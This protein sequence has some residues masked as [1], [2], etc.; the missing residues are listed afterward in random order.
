MNLLVRLVLLV[1]LAVLPA[2]GVHF[3]TQVRLR[4]AGE[5]AVREE[6]RRILHLVQAEQAR[7]FE[8]IRQVLL[9][10]RETQVLMS[11]EAAPCQ[12]FLE[13]IGTHLPAG[14]EIHVTDPEQ[15]VLCSSNRGAVGIWVGDREHIRQ[16]LA[17]GKFVIGS[18]INSRMNGKPAVPFAIGYRRGDGRQGVVTMSVGL[19]WLHASMAGKP[20]PP[21]TSIILADRHGAPLAQIPEPPG[22]DGALPAA[23]EGLIARTTDGTVE[24]L[25]PEGVPRVVAYS[26][27][28]AG[29]RGLFFA[30]GLDKRVVRA[31]VE[32]AWRFGQFSLG[33]ALAAAIAAAIGAHRLWLKRPIEAIVGVAEGW[34]RGDFS[35]R[36]QARGIEEIAHLSSA[37]NAVAEAAADR[38][39]SLSLAAS[40]ERR[41]ADIFASISDGVVEVGADGRIAFANDKARS[42]LAS[43]R[44]LVGEDL[45][46]ILPNPEFRAA[47]ERVAETGRAEEVESWHE[48][49]AHWLTVR[50]V[51]SAEGIAV[52][53]ADVTARR[54]AQLALQQADRER[55]AALAQ[56]ET[57]LENAPLGFAFFDA[58]HRFVRLN[59][60]LARIDGMSAAA[61]LGRRVED[62]MPANGAAIVP[63]LDEVLATGR[64]VAHHEMSGETP[65]QPGVRRHWLTSFYPVDSPGDS[66]HVGAVVMEISALKEAE[67]AL[68][69]AKEEAEEADLAKSKFLAAA[70]H[71]L[72]QPVQALLLLASAL[73][74]A[75]DRHPAQRLVDHVTVSVQSLQQLLEALLDVSRL[76]AGIVE[77][78]IRA[79]GIGELL[80]RL[81]DEYAPVAAAAGLRLQVVR[82]GGTVAT[83]PV[84]L[85]RVLRNLVE[86]AIRY[87]RKGGIV[88]GCRRRGDRLRIDVVDS[89]IGIPPEEHR[90]IFRE[91]VQI[92][93]PARDRNL[94]LG[95]GLS[96][97][98]RLAEVLDARIFVES[99]PGVGSRFSVE[100]ARGAS[101]V[102][103]ARPA[104]VDARG[105]AGSVLIIDDE[106]LLRLALTLQ[107]GD[108]GLEVMD[109][110]DADQAVRH[111]RFTG[112]APDVVI[113]DYRLAGGRTGIE[114]IAAVAA[115][116]GPSRHSVVLTGDTAPDRI[117][118]VR[119][120]GHHLLHKPVS[121]DVLRKR[122]ESWLSPVA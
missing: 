94:G 109:A 32:T 30:V 81:R 98:K 51:R 75:L 50:A 88:V 77:A 68:R 64:A 21:N 40:V 114:A 71:D 105:L 78:D 7:I 106:P 48:G 42:L 19:D 9:T 74:N 5:Q 101:A 86:N 59:D 79:V 66:R 47:F 58:E 54:S 62:L 1:C 121:P 10:V 44:R 53:I 60:V 89:G 73:R 70:S 116:A 36:L 2:I 11:G 104:I 24:L 82:C 72:R 113:A 69:A 84:L 35:V 83:D 103:P 28:D 108:W 65:A 38:E 46:D 18:R 17:T 45:R 57:L 41:M 22:G 25:D 23:Y 97:V 43:G 119:R 12:A 29:M 31:P 90:R 15:R 85:Q 120:S 61:H 56:L 34:S 52:A 55:R 102:E 16:A 3:H 91:F 4:E 6:A 95:L 96:I 80:D 115:V 117:A 63:I 122:L 20:L 39:R 99:T 76:D 33:L 87:T 100:M 112:V 27:A 92:D 107:L 13:R 49:G 8:G 111:V 37:L 93:N 14:Q 26:P 67:R 118:E 110:A